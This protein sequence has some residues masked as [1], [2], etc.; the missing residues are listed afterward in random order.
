MKA[1]NKTKFILIVVT[2][3]LLMLTGLIYNAYSNFNTTIHT[4]IDS[5]H[6]TCDGDCVCD[7]LE[8]NN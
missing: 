1:T 3:L 8:C 7:G 5:T 2:Y 6:I 4:C